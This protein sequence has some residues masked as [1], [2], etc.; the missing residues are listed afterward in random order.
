MGFGPR[1]THGQRGTPN[2]PVPHVPRVALGPVRPKGK[3][4]PPGAKAMSRITETTK[5]NAMI[6][7]TIGA[8]IGFIIAAS[9]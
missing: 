8:L 3:E 6:A 2:V 4:T 9:R 7:F 1:G 5:R